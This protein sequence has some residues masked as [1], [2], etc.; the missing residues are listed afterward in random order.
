MN[1]PSIR[2]KPTTEPADPTLRSH[3]TLQLGDSCC[4]IRPWAMAS[5]AWPIN[6]LPQFEFIRPSTIAF[7][8]ASDAFA[9]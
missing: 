5:Q 6:P 4:V 8:A 1:P 7:A 2:H 9:A 3:Q